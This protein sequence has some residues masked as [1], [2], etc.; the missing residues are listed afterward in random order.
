[1][2]EYLK[3]GDI[4][5][6]VIRELK[7]FR[8]EPNRQITELTV[9]H[10]IRIVVTGGVARAQSYELTGPF[11]ESVLEEVII[12]IA[13]IGVEGLHPATGAAAIVPF[14]EIDVIITDNGIEP[15]VKKSLEGLG[16]E[17]V[18]A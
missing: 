1:M 6:Y 9:R 4:S 2:P 5:E 11:A 16:V 17:I 8:D 10:Q 13:F 15:T 14:S 18:I 7:Y 3:T 12:D